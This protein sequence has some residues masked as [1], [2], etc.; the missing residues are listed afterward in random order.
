MSIFITNL[1]LYVQNELEMRLVNE[2]KQS[3]NELSNLFGG[4]EFV[5][6]AYLKSFKVS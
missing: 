6:N 2:D 1:N 5:P 3:H 4:L